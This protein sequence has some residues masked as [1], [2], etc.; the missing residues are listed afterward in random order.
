MINAVSVQ[1]RTVYVG[2]TMWASSPTSRIEFPCVGAT[3]E[4]PVVSINHR[5]P[6][7]ALGVTGDVAQK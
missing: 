4:L 3:H 5:D 1:V 2:G 7:A 6:F